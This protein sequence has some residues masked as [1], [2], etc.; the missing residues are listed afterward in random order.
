MTLRFS[1]TLGARAGRNQ[2]QKSSSRAAIALT[3]AFG[4]A[5]AAHAQDADAPGA[6]E[7]IVVT[8][9]RIARA[10]LD[11]NVPVAIVGEEAI[12]ESGAANIQDVLSEMPQ[13]GIG[14]TRTNTNFLTSGNGVASVNLRNLGSNRTL[15]LVNG[16][17]FVAG[18][19]GTSTV[20]INNIPT[21]FIERVEIV[22]GG[23]SAVYGSEAIAG[24]VNFILKK[25]FDGFQARAQYGITEM[26]DN[27]RYLASL[28]AGTEWGA[29]DRGSLIANFSY[30]KDDGLFSRDRAISREDCFLDVCGPASYSSVPAQGLFDAGGTRFTFD[31]NN[32]LVMGFPVGYGYNRNGDRRIA[33]PVE[34]YLGSAIANY[35][36][37]ADHTLFTEVTYSKVKSAA[38]IEP[39]ALVQEDIGTAGIPITSP[40][41]PQPI[42]DLI[43]QRNADADPTNDISAIGFRRRQNDIFSR[44]NINDRDTW[45]VATGVKGEIADWKYEAAYVFGQLKDHTETQDIDGVKY[46]AALDAIVDPATGQIVCRSAEARAAGCVPL[47][48]FGYDSASPAAAAYVRAVLPRTNDITNTQHVFSASISGAPLSLPAGDLGVALGGEYRREKSVDDWDQLTNT[49][50]NSGNMTPDTIGSYDVAEAYVETSLPILADLPFVRA[51]TANGAVRYSDYSTVGGVLSWNAGLEYEPVSGLRFRAVYSH[52]NRAPNIGELFSAP[53]ETFPTGITD[54]CNGTTATSSGTYAAACRAIPQVAAAIAARGAFT[55]TQADLQD[56]NGFNGG[57][58][59][60][61]EETAKTLTVGAVWTPRAVPGLSFSADYFDIKVDDAINSVPR[62]VSIEQCLLTGSAEFCDNVKRDAT[63]GQLRTI[64]ATLRNVANMRTSGIDFAARYSRPLDLL[65]GDRISLNLLYT[66][67]M[68]LEQRSFLG[69]PL[70]DNRGALP[71]DGRLGAGFKH[72]ATARLAYDAGPFAASWQVN[73]LGKIA[74]TPGLEDPD[75]DD[76]NRVGD[77]FYHDVQLR[78]SGGDRKAYEFYVGVDNLFDRKPPFLPSGMASNV[79]GTE[80]AADVYDPFGRRFYVGAQLK[81]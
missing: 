9:S 58:R 19:A 51:L 75:L 43:A 24:V 50:G 15:V 38:A 55:V 71:G 74:D 18:L 81:F 23:A 65:E 16:R 34:R 54:P 40:F 4:L 76:L 5:G 36:I 29:D 48:L 77:A 28:T 2:W 26:G 53:A 32:R 8:G 11:S 47:N 60:L 45:R 7:E 12:Q 59:D 6:D 17:R 73:Y 30:D 66:Y 20:D 41:I 67:L 78:Y 44:S 70:E 22:T 10:D 3:L 42:R 72:K 31:R 14:A 13:V 37:G 27:P 79:T 69:A 21:D 25:K 1:D 35:E 49:G 57:N 33:T 64:D 80:T 63:T 62:Q 68:K 39:L 61:K 52:A 46:R 56:I